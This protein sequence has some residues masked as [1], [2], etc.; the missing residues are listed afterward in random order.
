M[1]RRYKKE[2]MKEN[3]RIEE[4]INI[5]QQRRTV[6]KSKGKFVN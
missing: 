3:I 6:K 2:T 5:L 4:K 1:G